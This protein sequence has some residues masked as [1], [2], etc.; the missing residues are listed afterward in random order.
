MMG[1]K[2][3]YLFVVILAII[4][5]VMV[6]HS[7]YFSVETIGVVGLS[8]LKAGEVIKDS[9]IKK[10]DNIFLVPGREVVNRLMGN[11][12]IKGVKL[13]RH[14][15]D[16][17]VLVV[18]E[19]PGLAL[20]SK[21]DKLLELGEDGV[22]LATY[23]KEEGRPDLPSIEGVQSKVLGQQ[24]ELSPALAGTLS[25]LKGL[26]SLHLA[27]AK[28]SYVHGDLELTLDAGTEV[29]FGSQEDLAKNVEMFRTI[30]ANLPESSGEI[31]YIDLRYAGKPVIQMK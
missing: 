31:K 16:K 19:R 5:V 25:L 20:F 28:V 12:R 18:N 27:V 8:Q 11:V 30:I 21:V 13:E 15:P 3:V 1:N 17:I 6:M 14:F 24:M 10:G 4:G 29:Y 26:Y 2:L 22:I 23:G 7:P 9:G